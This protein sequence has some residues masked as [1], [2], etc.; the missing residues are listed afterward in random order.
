MLP[1]EMSTAAE[2]DLAEIWTHIAKNNRPAA[3]RVLDLIESR[4]QSIAQFPQIGS[5]R[6]DIAEDL[7]CC[8]VGN[9]GVFYRVK[10]ASVEIVRVLH[11]ARDIA[12]IFRH[13]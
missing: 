5:A 8:W 3:N 1:V 12:A 10:P 7:R 2:L 9:Y 13:Q 6:P 11:G 4:F